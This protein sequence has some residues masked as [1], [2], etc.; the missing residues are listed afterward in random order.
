MSAVYRVN[1]DKLEEKISQFNI[2]YDITERIA[3]INIQELGAF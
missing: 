3:C 1:K 2:L